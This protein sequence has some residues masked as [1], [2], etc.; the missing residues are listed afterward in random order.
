M[1]SDTKTVAGSGTG[2]FVGGA[3]GAADAE[4]LADVIVVME[5]ATPK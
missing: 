3:M 1:T 5:R 2:R 4:T